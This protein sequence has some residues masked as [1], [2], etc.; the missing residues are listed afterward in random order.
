MKD[1]YED[2]WET[3]KL[4]A[5]CTEGMYCPIKESTIN[6]CV[7]VEYVVNDKGE[8]VVCSDDIC[9][10]LDN[11]EEFDKFFEEVEQ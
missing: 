7:V 10:V 3:S 11:K 6:E 2:L 9:Y 1:D 4:K 8:Y 5:V